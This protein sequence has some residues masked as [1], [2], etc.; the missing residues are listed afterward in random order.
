MLTREANWR[1]CAEFAASRGVSAPALRRRSALFRCKPFKLQPASHPGL[2]FRVA[3]FCA[4]VLLG[5]RLRHRRCGCVLPRC[6]CVARNTGGVHPAGRGHIGL[7][8]GSLIRS[9]RAMVRAQA[10]DDRV[11]VLVRNSFLGVRRL[12]N[13]TGDGQSPDRL[14]QE[15][16]FRWRSRRMPISR[17][18]SPRPGSCFSRRLEFR[19]ASRSRTCVGPAGS[20]LVGRRLCRRR[21]GTAVPG[22][23][24]DAPVAGINRLLRAAPPTPRGR[25]AALFAT[26]AKH[27]AAVVHQSAQSSDDLLPSV[28]DPAILHDVERACRPHRRSD[29][30]F[31]LGV[32]AHL[33]PSWPRRSTAWDRAS[34]HCRVKPRILHLG[35]RIARS[36]LRLHWSRSFSAIGVGAQGGINALAALIYPLSIRATGA[37]WAL[38]LAARRRRWPPSGGALLAAHILLAPAPRR[39]RRSRWRDGVDGRAWGLQAL[40]VCGRMGRPYPGECR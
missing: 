9:A 10:G 19:W 12:P 13:P 29:S 34:S 38:G 28:V 27:G 23:G 5:R 40:D 32:I 25:V 11:R 18:R 39:S 21:R 15:A 1:A 24:A 16:A 20:A 2:S 17:P 37:G 31:S 14:K 7:L 30:V 8:L 26:G 36:A 33:R 3:C 4:A 22:A 6:R 35:D